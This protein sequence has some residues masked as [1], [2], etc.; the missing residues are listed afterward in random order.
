MQIGLKDKIKNRLKHDRLAKSTV[1]VAGLT[2]HPNLELP[3]GAL[4]D[5]QV[6]GAPS[7]R[8]LHGLGAQNLLGMCGGGNCDPSKPSSK[9]HNDHLV[10]ENDVHP[11]RAHHRQMQVLLVDSMAVVAELELEPV[12]VALLAVEAAHQAF[13]LPSH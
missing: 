10:V 12:E 13:W 4:S 3:L 1:A 6:P 5:I 7:H 11:R 8:A 9:K 2:P